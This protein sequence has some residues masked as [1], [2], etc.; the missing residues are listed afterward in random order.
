MTDAKH[1]SDSL[2]AQISDLAMKASRLKAQLKSGLDAD[3]FDQLDSRKQDD[4]A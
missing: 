1:N 3:D 4:A 2:E